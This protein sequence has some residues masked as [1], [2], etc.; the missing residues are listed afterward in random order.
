MQ[1]RSSRSIC[2]KCSS[3]RF[4]AIWLPR[5]ISPLYFPFDTSA[6]HL[7]AYYSFGRSTTSAALPEQLPFSTPIGYIHRL[8]GTRLVPRSGPQRCCWAHLSQALLLDV[9]SPHS[10]ENLVLSISP[11][12]Q[13]SDPLTTL[14][15]LYG[16][17]SKPFPLQALYQQIPMS[18]RR[19]AFQTMII[20]QVRR[21]SHLSCYLKLITMTLLYKARRIAWSYSR[22]LQMMW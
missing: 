4:S 6:N 22:S 3:R 20:T 12:V 1:G 5:A 18:F 10:T 19:M 7:V 8:R 17:C 13:D 9:S 11:R 15:R 16:N 14:R 2:Y 21:F